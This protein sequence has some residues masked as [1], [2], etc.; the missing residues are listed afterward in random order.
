MRNRCPVLGCRRRCDVLGICERHLRL[1]PK[2]AR[3]LLIQMA[4][5][6]LDNR[7]LAKNAAEAHRQAIAGAVAQLEIQELHSFLASDAP[8][9]K[10]QS[11]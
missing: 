1:V 6:A 10:R 7:A 9:D 2:P 4:E 11:F 8:A 3:R 5:V